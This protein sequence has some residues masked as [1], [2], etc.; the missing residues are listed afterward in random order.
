[1]KSVQ[2]SNGIQKKLKRYTIFKFDVWGIKTGS[3]ENL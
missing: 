2:I 1:M 3:K